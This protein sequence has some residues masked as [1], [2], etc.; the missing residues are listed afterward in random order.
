MRGSTQLGFIVSLVATLFI[1]G[2]VVLLDNRPILVSQ[3]ALLGLGLAYVSTLA[4]LLLPRMAIKSIVQRQKE[5]ELAPLQDRI[6]ELLVDVR[7]LGEEQH[8]ELNRLK[9]THDAILESS[10]EV[11]PLRAIGRLAG[12]LI[13]PTMTFL[14]T[15]FGEA[16][17]QGLLHRNH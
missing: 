8:K 9:E 5:R 4:G 2:F 12:A 13:L 3:V 16:F 10:E 7:Q 15:R 11:L 14:A 1:V 17:L 6:N